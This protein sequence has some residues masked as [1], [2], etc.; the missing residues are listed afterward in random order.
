MAAWDEGLS[1]DEWRCV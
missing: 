1:G